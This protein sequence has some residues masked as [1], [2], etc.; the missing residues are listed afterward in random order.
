MVAAASKSARLDFSKDSCYQSQHVLLMCGNAQCR[1]SRCQNGAVPSQ[2]V[3][4]AV[5]VEAYGDRL[6]VGVGVP[7]SGRILSGQ[8]RVMQSMLWT[9]VCILKLHGC[10]DNY[11]QGGSCKQ[12]RFPGHAK[13][14]PSPHLACRSIQVDV[15][16]PLGCSHSFCLGI[17]CCIVRAIVLPD[18]CRL[19]VT[20]LPLVSAE[21]RFRLPEVVPPW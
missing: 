1:C 18:L 5:D 4:S 6:R 16:I 13:S 14:Q 8:W 11:E 15:D 3:I 21:H 20:K 19:K 17:A 9:W 2:C 12:A 7:L 10:C